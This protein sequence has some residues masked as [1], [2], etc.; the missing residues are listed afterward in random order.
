MKN[1]MWGGRFRD[2]P[3][4]VMEEINASVDFDRALAAQDIAGSRAH[5][6]MLADRGIISNSDAEQIVAGLDK[7]ASEIEAG[8]FT[9]SRAAQKIGSPKWKPCRLPIENSGNSSPVCRSVL[10]GKIIHGTHATGTPSTS[11]VVLRVVP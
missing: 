2:A 11:K 9:F 7:I 8:T 10:R 5:A 4:A 3:D 6:R 1:T